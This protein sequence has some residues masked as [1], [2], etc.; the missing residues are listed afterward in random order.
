MAKHIKTKEWIEVIDLYKKFDRNS[1][2]NTYRSLSGSKSS[3]KFI[4]KLIANKIR[5]INNYGMNT[6]IRTKGSGRPRKRD[7]SDIPSIIDDLNEEEKREIIE[8]WIKEQRDKKDKNSL[9]GYRKLRNKMKPRILIFHRTTFYKTKIERK[10]KYDY[11][12]NIVF[13]IMEDNMWI[14]GSRKIVQKL[15]E[16]NICI[17]DRTL[18]NYMNKWHFVSKTRI[19]KRKSE[20]KNTN[21]RCED[22]VK[23]N[24]NPKDDNIIATDVSYIP[25]NVPD[26]HIYLSAAISH[27]TKLI[28]SWELSLDNN[29]DLVIKT[30]NKLERTKFIFHSD[31]GFQYSSSKVLNKLKEIGVK[32]SMSRIGNSLDNREIEYF[33]GCLKGEYLKYVNTSEMNIDQIWNHINHYINW[34]NNNRIQKRLNWKTPAYASASL[35]L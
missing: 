31:H 3:Y 27:K 16:I 5:M 15:E 21:V 35:S 25:A 10:Y 8:H 32:S 22:L 4:C 29:V 30:I 34:Y 19:K 24:Y 18:R 6:L 20:V 23:R 9:D 7:D 33:F 1:A 13:E 14:Y 11:L 12:K 2:V 26:R 17:S 28:E